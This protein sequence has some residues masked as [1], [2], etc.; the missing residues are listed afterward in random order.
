M[1]N[2]P[3]GKNWLVAVD[4]TEEALCAY[5]YCASE[6]VDRGRGDT[7][8]LVHVARQFAPQV[9]CR[10]GRR[11]APPTT[12]PTCPLAQLLRHAPCQ[13]D[14]P[15]DTILHSAPHT[16]YSVPGGTDGST[17]EEVGALQAKI[18]AYLNRTF[19][20]AADGIQARKHVFLERESAAAAQVADRIQ[21]V[22]RA[23]ATVRTHVRMR[24]WLPQCGA[25]RSCKKICQDEGP[26]L[27]S[28]ADC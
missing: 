25:A 16:T 13:R 19:P 8:H 23:A 24:H 14:A 17:S 28:D 7:L 11:C 4:T 1:A 9:R 15:Q 20:A 22:G 3:A 21:E 2:N 26:T 12:L 5:R 27:P 10:H 18:E 6:L